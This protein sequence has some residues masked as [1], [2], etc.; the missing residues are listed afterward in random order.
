GMDTVVVCNLKDG[1]SEEV[2]LHS[3]V[4]NADT[5]EWYKNGSALPGETFSGLD[6]VVSKEAGAGKYVCRASNACGA[7]LD[8]C[9]VL[10]DSTPRVELMSPV[11]KDTLCE[12][13]EWE[14]KVKAT[15]P[16][17][18]VLGTQKLADRT[19]ETLH[20]DD[21]KESDG[22]TYFVVV[23]NRC[24]QRKEEV[25]SLVVDRPV[26]II[27]QQ[28]KFSI[29][30]QKR[31][32]PYLF[33][34]TD[35]KERVYYRW[36]DRNGKVLGRANELTNID[37]NVYTGLV[38]TFRVHYG[39]R[40]G[41]HY[42][43]VTLLTN[44][45]IQFQQPVEEIAVCVMDQLPDT[46]LSVKVMNDQMVSYK[47]FKQTTFTTARDSVGNTD[48][49]H[50]R[51]NQSKYA[52]Y[53]YCYIANQCVDT[54]SR[55]ASVRIDTI[56]EVFITLPKTDTLCSGSEMKLKVSGRAGNSG[57]NYAWYVKKKGQEAKK[58][59]S[60]Y[61]FGLSQ[62]EYSCFVDTTYN[63]A[64]VWCD[65]STACTRPMADT[66][67]L[68]ILPAPKVEMDVKTEWTC[69]GENNEVY[70]SMRQDA[71]VPWKYKYS[72]DGKEDVTI[73]TVNGVTD[74]LRVSEAG[75]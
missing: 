8:T 40:C 30:R 48:S 50:V 52:G 3:R 51:L 23:D 36:E 53:Y 33:I 34:Q 58:M 66:M 6:V 38:D 60:A 18:W 61:Y 37:L 27:S 72:L 75:T 5:W 42:K 65:I 49:L 9:L 26:N 22:G 13:T 73:R 28:D 63:D 29:C 57:L 62:S 56:P 16:V 74:T 46:V 32:F 25:A 69:E 47:W 4:A 15:S 43:D 12:G 67:R 35:P 19:E 2:R 10:V 45:V 44:D 68:T 70:V 54:V 7:L 64:L 31:E 17:Y 39:N 55:M 24:G 20:I 59:A 41:D 1:A 11:R 14:L 21:V 71:G